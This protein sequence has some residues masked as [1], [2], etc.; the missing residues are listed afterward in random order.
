MLMTAAGAVA[1]QDSGGELATVKERELEQVRERISSLKQ[2]MDRS[3]TQRDRLTG[4]LQGIEIAGRLAR[5]E[6][7][8]GSGPH[9]LPHHRGRRLNADGALDLYIA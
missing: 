4:E 3:A 2:S 7:L 8:N 6:R 1:A 9:S 5:C